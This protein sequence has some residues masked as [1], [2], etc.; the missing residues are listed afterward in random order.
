MT[1]YKKTIG[2]LA[3]AR[4]TNTSFLSPRE[5]DIS[6]KHGSC[7]PA[8][9]LLLHPGHDFE[10]VGPLAS[11]VPRFPPRQSY[12]ISLYTL[13][14]AKLYDLKFPRAKI[15]PAGM[16]FEFVP[17]YT[18]KHLPSKSSKSLKPTEYSL[19]CYAHFCRPILCFSIK[20]R[21]YLSPYSN[22]R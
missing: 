18:V 16:W 2:I 5:K 6:V 22:F 20:W 1:F 7:F 21:L 9:F 12:G 14:S 17:W 3:R 4:P 19:Y 10:S 8:P 11:P 13:D 15:L